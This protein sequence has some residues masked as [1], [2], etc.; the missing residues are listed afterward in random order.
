LSK[1]LQQAQQEWARSGQVPRA[2][3][4]Q[5]DARFQAALGALQARLEQSRRQAALAQADALR[6]KLILCQKIEEIISAA[7]ANADAAIESDWRNRWQALPRLAPAFEKVVAA[8]F[9]RALQNA[10]N[11][12]ATLE[13]QRPVLQQELLRAEILAGI[14]SPP[15]LSRE[16]LQ[17]QVE[18]LQ[19]S[20]KAGG[21]AKNIEQQLLHICDL[22]ALMD[23]AA[24]Q[25]LLKLVAQ[26]KP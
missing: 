7:D 11:Y 19:A 1:I 12:A 6:D 23:E 22:P 18:V 20:L 13:N 17:L 2:A 24:L 16:R 15:A 26:V 10:G 14:D 8:R 3:Q 9:E 4:A 25:R 21:S 5:I